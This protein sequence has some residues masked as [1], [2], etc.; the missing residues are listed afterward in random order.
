MSPPAATP[1][2]GNPDLPALARRIKA[3]AHASGFQRC[4]I[5]GIELGADEDHLRDWLAQGLYGSMEWMARHGEKRARPD[6]LIPGAIPTKH[7][8]RSTTGSALTS[9]A[10][11]WAATT[12]S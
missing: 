11:P 5:S 6:E 7:G 2:P 8:R 3:L 10:T 1:L 4:G 12:T 9:R